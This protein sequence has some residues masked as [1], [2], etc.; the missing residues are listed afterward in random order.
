MTINIESMP[1]GTAPPG[2]TG[3]LTGQG[4]PVRWEILE[5]ASAP[6]G[7]VISETSQ[8]S[9]DYRFPLCI[10]NGF[11]ARDVEASVRFK[12]VDGQVDRAAG[13]IVRVQD[14][15]NY[16]VARAN[17]L[18]ANVRLYKV[19]DGVRRQIGGH[20]IEVTSGVWHT[21]SLSISGDVLQVAYDGKQIIQTNDT[22][23]SEPGKVGLWT[24]ADSLTHFSD[25]NFR[26]PRA[27][28]DAKR[29]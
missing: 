3:A 11:T 14:P 9:A 20:N 4:E 5:D 19:T 21:L 6:G 10:F 29:P 16:Y 7:R 12:A 28:A 27:E 1:L 2:F 13:I 17:A 18:E 15:Q 22:A 24:K 23:I 25:F 8:D 26:L